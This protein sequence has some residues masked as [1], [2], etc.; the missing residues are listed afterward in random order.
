MKVD[1]V[2]YERFRDA[3]NA[4]KPGWEIT[5]RGIVGPDKALVR[6]EQRHTSTSEGHLDV[7][8]VLEGESSIGP[9]LWDCVVGFGA[10]PVERAESAAHLWSQ[11]TAGALLEFKYSLRGEFADHYRGT[12]PEGFRGWH[13]ICGPILGYGQGDSA[14]QLQRWWLE[15]PM[16]PALS[17]VLN[18]SLDECSCPHGIKILFGG[19]GVAEVRLNGERHEAGSATLADFPWPRLEPPSFVRSY[20]IV[21]HRD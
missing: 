16:L 3:L 18:D 12:E 1:A 15:N 5:E 21:L 7:Q 20:L 19:D 10:T 11:T 13:V 17:R 4:L 8:F 14:E 9:Q 6:F 2:T